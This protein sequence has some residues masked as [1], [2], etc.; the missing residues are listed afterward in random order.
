MS[1]L[2]DLY[3]KYFRVEEAATDQL[4]DVAYSIRY[5][6][7]C[8]EN[9]FEDP[10]ANASSLE[11]DDYDTHSG[12]ALLFHKASG[13]AAGTVRMVLPLRDDPDRSFALQAVCDDPMI[14]REDLF[15][16][17]RMGE[18]SRFCVT[19]EFRR[20]IEDLALQLKYFPANS[21][22]NADEWRRVIPNMTLGLIE[23]L[24]RFS[25]REGLTHWC[26]VMEPKLL[27]LLGRLGIYFE[28]IGGLVDYHGRRQPCFVEL[29]SLLDRVARERPDVWEVISAKGRHSAD[30]EARYS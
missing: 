1:S 18:I 24:V 10:G 22:M 9:P 2:V 25:V 26:A 15:P 29:A 12:H 28:P 4:K 27:R 19:K 3:Y 11:S 6:V 21:E 14:H 23:W 5:Q 8:I 30:L 7:Y 17:R 13:V 16:V 20:R